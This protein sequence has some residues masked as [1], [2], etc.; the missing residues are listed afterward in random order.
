MTG[1]RVLI[2]SLIMKKTAF[3]LWNLIWNF[4]SLTSF[5]CKVYFVMTQTPEND[6]IIFIIIILFGQRPMTNITFWFIWWNKDNQNDMVCFLR[7]ANHDLMSK[8]L[9]TTMWPY[10]QPCDHIDN[11]VTILT[12]MW[13]YWQPRHQH[14]LYITTLVYVHVFWSSN[15]I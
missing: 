2:Y 7:Y 3:Q 4:I 10:W 5:F 13:P 6:T 14:Y 1:R 12:T 15:W 8:K 9:V 11:H